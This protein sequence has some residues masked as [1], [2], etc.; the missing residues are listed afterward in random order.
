MVKNASQIVPDNLNTAVNALCQAAAK[1]D[2]NS[3]MF[4]L[5]QVAPGYK[6]RYTQ[7]QVSVD[8]S[9]NSYVIEKSSE[10]VFTRIEP[11][12]T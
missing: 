1:N 10:K 9:K 6:P 5:E 12:R 4:L 7:N 11:Q 2:A 3:I 8:S